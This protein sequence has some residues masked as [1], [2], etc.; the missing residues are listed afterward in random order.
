[1]GELMVGLA[2]YFAFY[3]GERPHQSLGYTTPDVESRTALGDGAVIVDK[4]A[5]VVAGPLRYTP[6]G[7]FIHRRSKRRRNGKTGTAPSIC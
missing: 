7:G 5:R 3:N 4:F 2:A 1:M 6:R